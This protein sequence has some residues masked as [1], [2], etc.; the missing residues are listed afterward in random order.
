MSTALKR[1]LSVKAL[2]RTLASATTVTRGSSEGL[3]SAMGV[4]RAKNCTHGGYP[5]ASYPRHYQRRTH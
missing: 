3:K 2:E 5:P 4:R 1:S